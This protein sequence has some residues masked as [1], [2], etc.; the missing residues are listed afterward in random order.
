[1]KQSKLESFV[2][3][4]LNVSIGFCISFMAWPVVAEMHGLP[5]GVSQALSITAIFTVLSVTR[6]YVVRRWFNAGLSSAAHQITLKL[7]RKF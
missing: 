5:Y 7:R 3:T 1:M 6:G 2:E 4:C